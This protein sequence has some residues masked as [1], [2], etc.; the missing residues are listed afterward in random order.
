ML[1]ICF[2]IGTSIF[3]QKIGGL[4]CVAYLYAFSIIPAE[5][6]NYMGL[7]MY[8]L[9][10]SLL[11]ARGHLKKNRKKKLIIL[12]LILI[13]LCLT[14]LRFGFRIFINYFL[15]TTGGILVIS[16]YTFF[17][18]AYYANTLVYEEKKLNIANYPKLTERDCRILQKIQKGEKYSVIA[19]DENI[20]EGSL[21]NRLH[22]VFDTMETG[23][24]QGFLSYY[25]DW[26]LYYN[27]QT[28]EPKNK[29]ENGNLVD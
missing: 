9:G 24:K 1:A 22:F 3:P 14:H 26:K 10:T 29:Q 16:L 12:G 25:D 11:I 4:S 8:F 21:K 23:D 20:T 2:F 27:P 18:N 15:G 5:P 17:M 7:L 19:K 13:L 28:S 6:E